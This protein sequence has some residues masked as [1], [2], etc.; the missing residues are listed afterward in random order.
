MRSPFAS[1]MERLAIESP[2]MIADIEKD[3][4]PMMALLAAKGNAHESNFLKSLQDKHGTETIA[5]VKSKSHHDKAL[6]TLQY[7]NDGYPFI[8]QAYLSRDGFAGSADFLVKLEGKSSLGDYHYE[9]WDTKLSQTT[10]PYFLIQLCCYSWMLESIQ[11]IIPNEAAIV[12]GDLTEDRFRIARY[13]SFF[14]RLK[15]DFLNAQYAFTADFVCMPDPAYYSDHGAWASFAKDWIERTDSL[16]QIAGIRKSHIRKLRA[17]GVETMTEFAGN[18]IE[19]VKGIPNA[20][21]AKLKAQ[22]E[23]QHASLGLEKPL[24]KILQNDNGKGL[25]FL[26][27]AS[28]FDVFFDIEGH[29][30]YDGGLEYLWGCSYRCPDAAQG[31]LYAFRLGL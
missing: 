6:E 27:P 12:L 22:A 25:S 17:A 15:R 16:A 13:Y 26:P 5:I 3:S 21:L 28:A 30:L 9:A 24:F 18:D 19:P 2:A 23:I 31:K 20:T 29:P 11:G 14:D 4:D 7:M 1:W 8:Y 10:R